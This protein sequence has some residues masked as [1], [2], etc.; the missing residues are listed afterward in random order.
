MEKILNSKVA[1][2]FDSYPKNIQSKLLYLRQLILETASETDDL[3]EVQETLKWGEPSY[4]TKNGS[5][6]RVAWKKSKPDQYAM[7]FN[8]KTKLI[9]TFRELFSDRF[10]FE[11]N[12]SIV[13]DKDD[14][15]PV[16]ELKYCILL[17]LTYH[18]RK[19]LTMLDS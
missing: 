13:F 10:N 18:K 8:C 7:Y 1:D 19:H 12:R 6:V 14:D 9:S 16:K 4:L 11:G 17:S 15:I 2:V 3:D 5:T